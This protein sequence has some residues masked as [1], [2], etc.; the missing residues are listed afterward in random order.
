MKLF[1][2]IVLSLSVSV[3]ADA[4][5]ILRV[6]MADNAR[7]NVAVNGRYFNKRGTTVTVG[8]LP[9][10]RHNVKVYG[11][12]YDRWGRQYDRLV[13]QGTV[14]TGYGM[15]TNLLYDPYT[16]RV[17]IRT[18]PVEDSRYLQRYGANEQ[19]RTE[20]PD[21][22][23]GY[24]YPGEENAV[25]AAGTSS[26]SLPSVNGAVSGAPV[27]SPVAMGSFTE[28][29]S[30]K[31]KKAIEA[32]ATDTEK[33]KMVRESLKKEVVS[34]YQVSYIMDW[35]LFESTKLEFAR[36]AYPL[37][38]DQENYKDLLAKFSYSS[39][40]EEMQEFLKTKK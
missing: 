37:V 22:A 33:L 40:K 39:S 12:T 27:A 31:L 21:N 17:S 16:R 8:D 18:N 6:H 2:A 26:N 5:S 32:K 4:Q 38:A 28:E 3:A 14:S 11:V 13:Y 23:S 29:K 25:P 30:D 7:I 10:G 35:F 20:V 24:E 15:I 1:A 19:Y 36:W 34:T 9:P